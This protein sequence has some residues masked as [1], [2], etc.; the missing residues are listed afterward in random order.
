MSVNSK[1]VGGLSAEQ[2]KA[3]LAAI[4]GGEVRL[5]VLN[6]TASLDQW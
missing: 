6:R 2:V 1:P 3:L 4:P 5:Q